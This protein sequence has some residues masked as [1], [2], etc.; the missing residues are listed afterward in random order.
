MLQATAAT[1]HEPGRRGA[2][3]L[4]LL[5][6]YGVGGWLVR[7]GMLPVRVLLSSIGYTFSLVFATQG[8]VQTL[9]DVRR[10]SGSI[11]RWAMCSCRQA[12]PASSME[13]SSSPA[14]GSVLH[15]LISTFAGTQLAFCLRWTKLL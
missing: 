7:Q 4:S 6:L 1:Q 14:G 10:V 2:I 13:A 3:H 8:V 11:S 12:W 15:G 5:A 9:A